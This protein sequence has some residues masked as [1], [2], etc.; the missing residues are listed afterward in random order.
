MEY[1]HEGQKN[2]KR[3][4]EIENPIICHSA[5][6]E[7]NKKTKLFFC[8]FARKKQNQNRKGYQN[9][10]QSQKEAESKEKVSSATPEWESLEK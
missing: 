1:V 4:L 9:M 7:E 8:S 6:G 5:E 3:N 10:R 2:S